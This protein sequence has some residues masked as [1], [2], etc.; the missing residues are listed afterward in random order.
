MPK[1][2]ELSWTQLRVGLMVIV[3]L[4]IFMVAI[5][6]ITGRGRLLARKYTLQ[7]FLPEAQGLKEGAPVRLAGVEVGNVDR[8]QLSPYRGQPAK[9][10]QIT[11]RV[12]KSYQPDIRADSKASLIT[13]GLL[14]ERMVDITRGSP[15]EP[16]IKDGGTVQGKEEAAIK[17]IIER[18]NEVV[19]NLS[20][21]TEQIRDIVSRVQAGQ[22]TIGKLVKDETLYNR[23]NAAVDDVHKLTQQAAAG[24]GTLGKLIV[25]NELY[26]RANATM[27]RVDNI[28]A[29]VEA[30]KGTVGKFLRDEALAA[31]TKQMIERANSA[32]GDI[33]AGKGTLGKLAKDPALYDEAKATFANLKSVTSKLDKGGGSLERLIDDPRLYENANGLAEDLRS[34]LADFRSNPKKYMRFKFGVLVF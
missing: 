13:E 9:S 31:Q 27:R 6:Y 19:S 21:M 18:T 32:F 5:F 8:V 16:E 30:G 29:D 23:V 15:Q 3:A 25:S 24:E 17:L 20:V 34:F 10:V 28:V 2:G 22:G 33:E 1:R 12:L 26:D 7:T 4:M 14:G 11:M